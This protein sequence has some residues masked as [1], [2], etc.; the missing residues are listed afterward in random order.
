MSVEVI[1]FTVFS[2]VSIVAVGWYLVGSRKIVA[3]RA[4]RVSVV[5]EINQGM[6]TGRTVSGITIGGSEFQLLLPFCSDRDTSL[7]STVMLW[8]A[9]GAIRELSSERLT[10]NGRDDKLV[11]PSIEDFRGGIED[12][13]LVHIDSDLG[14][15]KS[16]VKAWPSIYGSLFLIRGLRLLY[17]ISDRTR[18]LGRH[19]FVDFLGKERASRFMSFVLECRKP[20]GFSETPR[21][22][23]GTITTD[24]G[25]IVE[26]NLGLGLDLASGKRYMEG[27]QDFILRECMKEEKVASSQANGAKSALGFVNDPLIFYAPRDGRNAPCYSTAE[28]SEKPGY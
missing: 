16:H 7:D 11:L 13:L 20:E 2:V 15:A 6:R 1:V 28:P 22:R 23:F 3:Q 8:D 4:Q 21:S 5:P 10:K 25:F 9:I 12:C 14:G 27:V 17:G 24:S 18:P 19:E 26:W